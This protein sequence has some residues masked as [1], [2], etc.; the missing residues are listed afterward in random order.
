MPLTY[1]FDAAKL[2]KAKMAEAHLQVPP[3]IPKIKNKEIPLHHLGPSFNRTF[4][5]DKNY[6][7]KVW[8]VQQKK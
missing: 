3:T 6:R 4:L 7:S 8:Y 1:R 2:D 5:N